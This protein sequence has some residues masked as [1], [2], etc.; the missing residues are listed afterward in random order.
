[1]SFSDVVPGMAVEIFRVAD[2]RYR[3]PV[4]SRGST[5]NHPARQPSQTIRASTVLDMKLCP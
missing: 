3:L 5:R 4:T 1:M 2:D